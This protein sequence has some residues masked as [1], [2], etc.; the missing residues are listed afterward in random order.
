[1]NQRYI[2]QVIACYYATFLFI[3]PDISEIRSLKNLRLI[4]SNM[5]THSKLS[6]AD[7]HAAPYHQAIPGFEHM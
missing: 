1:M 2:K 4:I 7:F 5:T 6:G 3:F